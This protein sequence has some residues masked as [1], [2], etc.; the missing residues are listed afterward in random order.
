MPKVTG[1]MAKSL[2]NAVFMESTLEMRILV[3]TSPPE[4][5]KPMKPR[6]PGPPESLTVTM[7]VNFG[8]APSKAVAVNVVFAGLSC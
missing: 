3:M 8:V 5:L 1:P 2:L 4:A 7:M 6:L